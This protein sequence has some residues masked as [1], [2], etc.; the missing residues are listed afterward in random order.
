MSRISIIQRAIAISAILLSASCGRKP[1]GNYVVCTLE[2][3]NAVQNPSVPGQGRGNP[4]GSGIYS[5]ELSE[6]GSTP[7]LLT[8]DF[9]SAKS[10][11]LSYDGSNMLF[12]GRKN[13]AG[14]WA[15]WEMNLRTRKARIITSGDADCTDP[16]YLP[17]ERLAY[18]K[19]LTSDSL[20]A[21]QAIYT[22]G[23]DGGEQSRITFNPWSYRALAV[24]ADGRLLATGKQCFPDPGKEMI[25]VM[26]PDGTKAEM[27]YSP[28]DGHSTGRRPF[29]TK[30]GKIVF[31]ES[32]SGSDR[33]SV[34]NVSY[35][36][37][38]HSREK[39]SWLPGADVFAAAASRTG[40]I[41]FAFSRPGTAGCTLAEFTASEE[42][43]VRD[44]FNSENYI[45]S[46]IAFIEQYQR[47]RKLPSEV[48]KGVKS[49]LMLCQNINLTGFNAPEIINPDPGA[50]KVE[51]LGL[52][53]SLGIIDAEEDGSVYLKIIADSPF[54]LRTLDK[55]GNVVSGPGAWLYLRPNERRG[56]A[57]CHED[58]EIVPA[59]RM[60]QAVRKQ[61]VTVPVEITGIREKDIEL[62]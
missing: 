44:I 51:I 32:A 36:R 49:G 14:N 20:K 10:P 1:D 11:S 31:T 28:P 37:P 46:E 17:G 33:G 62:E 41:V 2:P 58:Q 24:L 59:N 4:A 7:E 50:I 9:Y 57:G 23:L 55:A 21:E 61:P 35:S 43:S 56:C 30:D 19:H 13:E 26:R 53:R 25:M 22:A 42:H 29:E 16:V 18:V 52:D 3:V 48:D 47:P 12:S 60:A 45:I 6:T 5:I 38:L 39:A 8:G 15:V 27:F 54:R 34:I 40:R